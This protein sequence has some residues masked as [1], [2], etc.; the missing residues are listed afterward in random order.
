MTSQRCSP[1]TPNTKRDAV[2]DKA[3]LLPQTV[4]RRIGRRPGEGEKRASVSQ[5]PRSLRNLLQRL[6]KPA[7][8]NGRLQKTCRWAL[9]AHGGQCSTS[10]IID[11]CYA[12]RLEILGERRRRSFSVA[13]RRALE[14]IGAKRIGRATT[15]SRPWIWSAPPDDTPADDK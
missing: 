14:S 1:A 2:P 3:E 10:T 6:P 5:N 13:V 4:R 11:W 12:R 8:G 9:W 15:I 7:K